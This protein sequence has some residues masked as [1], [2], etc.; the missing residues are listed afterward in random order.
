MLR[1]FHLTVVLSTVLMSLLP[2]VAL[3]RPLQIKDQ[4]PEVP[5]L[6]TDTLV[7]YVQI[8]DGSTLDLGKLCRKTQDSN[9]RSSTQNSNRRSS[10]SSSADKCYFVDA[11]GRPCATPQS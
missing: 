4:Y 1:Y 3:T 5:N 8:E 10:R 11:A 6:N 7:C 9:S 2:E